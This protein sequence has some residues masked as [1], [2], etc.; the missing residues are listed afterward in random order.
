[1]YAATFLSGNRSTTVGRAKVLDAAPLSKPL[2]DQ[3]F[4][5][6]KAPRTALI[7]QQQG[8]QWLDDEG[9]DWSDEIELSIPDNDVFMIDADSPI[10]SASASVSGVGTVLF[11]MALNPVTRSLYVSNTE[12]LNRVR[13]EGPGDTASTVRGHFI[14]NRITVVKPASVNPVHLNESI[15]FDLEE[16]EGIPAED[17]ARAL[18]QPQQMVLSPDGSK[19]YLAAFDS[20]KVAVVDTAQLEAGNY[21]DQQVV[22]DDGAPAGLALNETGDRLYVYSRYGHS[23]LLYDTTTGEQLNRVDIFNPEPTKIS[24]GRRFLYDADLSSAT[25]TTSCGG[26]HIFGNLDA[27]AWDLGN[28]DGQLQEKPI[29]IVDPPSV[30][31]PSPSLFHPMKG[32]MTTQTFRGINDSGPMHW[33]G[34]RTG[35]VPLW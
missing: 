31:A 6:F 30:V 11:N 23:V 1:V 3:N 32:P 26:C 17:K 24:E 29:N 27:L 12:A 9:Q 14:E 8:N 4:E 2:P 18:A 25:G 28:P 21:V 20:N 5:G 10:P 16:E 13:F 15:D 35:I 34:D 7:V 22:I 33:R 19:L